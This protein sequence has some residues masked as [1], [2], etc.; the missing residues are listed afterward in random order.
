[1]ESKKW[2]EE[3]LEHLRKQLG[4]EYQVEKADSRR[5]SENP[6]DISIS[7]QKAGEREGIMI[8]L[9]PETMEALEQGGDV[10]PAAEALFR[11]YEEHRKRLLKSVFYTGSFQDVQETIFYA[12][13]SRTAEQDFSRIPHK[14][15][16][17]MEIVFY[18]MAE[19]ENRT[20]YHL[21]RNQDTERWGVGVEE[22]WQAARKNTPG[23]LG[24]EI[25]TCREVLKRAELE[26]A[27]SFVERIAAGLEKSEKIRTPAFILTNDFDMF[28]TSAILYEGVLE[29]TAAVWNDDLLVIP[30]SISDTII[31]PSSKSENSV[32]EWQATIRETNREMPSEEKTLTDSVY[33]YDRKKGLLQIAGQREKKNP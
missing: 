2:L 30:I 13:E 21:V 29:R 28:G 14:A 33:F 7:V 15:Y 1:M 27:E 4:S 19:S 20:F 8:N 22:L 26:N 10:T 3:L 25:L 23:L 18:M 9:L 16:L 17:D 12:L 11:E 32:E 31:L 5:K 24:M 6:D